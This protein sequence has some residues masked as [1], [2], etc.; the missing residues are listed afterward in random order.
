MRWDAPVGPHLQE[1]INKPLYKIIFN[2]FNSDNDPTK[3]CHK[4][5][6]SS[7][8]MRLM[9]KFIKRL[10]SEIIAAEHIAT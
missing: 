2:H 9:V 6:C 7:S 1:V 10:R 8:F 5:L 3:E 4:H